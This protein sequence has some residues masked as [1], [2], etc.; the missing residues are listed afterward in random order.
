MICKPYFN[1]FNHLSGSRVAQ[2]GLKIP[3][4]AV[5]FRPRPPRFSRCCAARTRCGFFVCDASVPS[6]RHAVRASGSWRGRST[7]RSSRCWTIRPVPSTPAAARVA[8]RA[9]APGC[10]EDH[11]GETSA[12]FRLLPAPASMFVEHRAT[13][14]SSL[15]IGRWP[16]RA[17]SARPADA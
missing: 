5:R 4:S 15:S 10:A 12:R 1:L 2:Q 17:G 8:A 11:A 7:T 16:Q 3:V 14:L 6:I 9:M 13:G